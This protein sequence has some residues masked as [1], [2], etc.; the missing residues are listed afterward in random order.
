[1]GSSSGAKLFG[2]EIAFPRL[3]QDT[4]QKHNKKEHN[5]LKYTCATRGPIYINNR[6]QQFPHERF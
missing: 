1:M 2:E 4:Q 6:R 5:Q 3:E